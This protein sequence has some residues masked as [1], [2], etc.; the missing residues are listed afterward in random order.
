MRHLFF[1][2][3]LAVIS[4]CTTS[5]KISANENKQPNIILIYTDD[6]G[7][8]DLGCYGSPLIKTP[9]LDQIAEEGIKL[10]NFYVASSVC[11]ASR[12]ALL[13]GRRASRNG[14]GGVFFPDAKGMNPSEITIA[15]VLKSS[16]YATAS[17]GKWHLGDFDETLPT[18]QGFDEYFGVPYSNDMYIGAKQKFS[19]TVKFYDGYTLEKAQSDQKYVKSHSREEI[20]KQGIKELVP[21]MEGNQIV[22]YPAQQSSLTKRYFDRTLQFI[23]KNKKDSP[24][25]VYLTPAMP[26]VPLFA[27]EQFSGKSERGL[28]GDVIEEIDWNIGRLRKYLKE[29]KLEENTIIIYTSDN[30][31]WL[32]YG[33]HAGSALPLRDGKF[34]NFEGGIRVPALVYWKGKIDGGIEL[35]EIVSNMDIFPTLA[36]FTKANL[37]NRA[38]DGL[39]I[40]QF[41]MGKDDHIDR[42]I[43]FYNIGKELAG[44]RKGNWK[45]LREKASSRRKNNANN[46]Q[47]WLFNLAEDIGES[48]NLADKYPEKIEEFERILV[49]KENEIKTQ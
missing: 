11:S 23:E 18:G 40:S 5:N 1:P 6:Q 38:L 20:K 43:Y 29:N 24:F 9:Q 10:T 15:E 12:A 2:I 34:T 26:H 8:Q 25:F 30:G 28:Y 36:Q 39:D 27:S 33:D 3:L 16:G 47:A 17:F 46:K 49:E 32:G 41:L 4:A 22:E 31:P 21:L 13:T 37:P 45:Y 7:Y 14:V 42:E 44:L 35:N 48:R 19:D